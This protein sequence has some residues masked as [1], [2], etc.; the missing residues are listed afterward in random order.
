[1]SEKKIKAENRE[2]AKDFVVKKF[3]CICCPIGCELTATVKDDGE[4]SV[5]GN[6]CKR[7]AAYA[8]TELT[9]PTR[10]VTSTVRVNGG[11]IDRVPV[12]TAR[13]IPKEKMFDALFGDGGIKSVEVDAPIEA[14]DVVIRDVAGTGVDVIATRKIERAIKN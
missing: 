11:A 1:M 3:V 12:K 14:G 2:K 4:I 5:T 7:G 6:T 10:T 8:V 9:A 13:P